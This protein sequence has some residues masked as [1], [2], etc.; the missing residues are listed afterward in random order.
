[1]CGGKCGEHVEWVKGITPDILSQA[2]KVKILRKEYKEEKWCERAE[3]QL[4]SSVK[5]TSNQLRLAA[6]SQ[7]KQEESEK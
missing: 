1:M 4:Y 7:K 2:G 3:K 6:S 5:A